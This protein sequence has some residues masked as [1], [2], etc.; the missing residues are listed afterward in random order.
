MTGM[1]RSCRVWSPGEGGDG[2]Q[3]EQELQAVEDEQDGAEHEL[4]PQDEGLQQQVVDGQRCTGEQDE[5]RHTRGQ[6]ALAQV[7]FAP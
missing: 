6:R 3:R 7:P 4:Q 2:E 5:E 1:G